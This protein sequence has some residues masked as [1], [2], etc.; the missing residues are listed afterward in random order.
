VFAVPPRP[1][2]AAA[3]HAEASRLCR[4]L[5]GACVSMQ[6]WRLRPKIMEADA[7][8]DGGPHTL[9]EV[10][11]EL[12]F[13]ELARW[14]PVPGKKTWNGHCLRRALLDS[15]GIVVPDRLDEAGTVPVDDVLDA[16]AV[17]WSTYRIARGLAVHLPDPADQHD[18]R[19][20]PIVIWF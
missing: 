10:H 6:A 5:A 3:E 4:E 1:V 12:A 13:A 8:R 16:A 7:Y 15:A 20:R 9:F 2:W 17:A 19:G 11:P 18:E 14:A